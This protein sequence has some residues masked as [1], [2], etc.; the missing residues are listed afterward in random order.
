MEKIDLL[1]SKSLI[2]AIIDNPTVSVVAKRVQ[3]SEGLFFQS[4]VSNS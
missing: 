2:D 3:R 1:K 4:S